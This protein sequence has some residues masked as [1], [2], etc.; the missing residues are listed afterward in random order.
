MCQYE[1]KNLISLLTK[2]L[3]KNGLKCRKI[4]RNFLKFFDARTFH[5]LERITKISVIFFEYLSL[6]TSQN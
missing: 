1:L 2:E 3:E 5:V 4:N 6:E